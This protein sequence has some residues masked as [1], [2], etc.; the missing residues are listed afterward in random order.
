MEEDNHWDERDELDY[1]TS[2]WIAGVTHREQCF[3]DRSDAAQARLERGEIDEENASELK[4]G[5]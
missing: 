5:A 2:L 4:M 1:E 3:Y